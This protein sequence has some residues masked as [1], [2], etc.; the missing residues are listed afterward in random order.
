VRVGLSGA[1]GVGK[2]TLVEALGVRLV[3]SGEHVAVLAVDP[4]STR[5]GGSILGDKTRMADLARHPAAFIRPSPSRG[6]LGGVTRRTREVLLLCEAAGFG[7]V[8]VETVGVGQSEVAVADLV[9]TFVLLIGPGGGDELQGV[10]RG[11]MEL[12]D[13]IAVTK[14]DGDLASAAGRVQA[15]H[16]QAVAF[17]R[18]RHPAWEP[19]VIACSGLTGHGVDELWQAVRDHRHTIRADLGDIRAGQAVRW[20]WD[21]VEAGLVER[22]MAETGSARANE[23]EIAVRER[24]ALPAAEARR[25]L[26]DLGG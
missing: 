19:R 5:S 18:R 2:S 25:L 23:A 17:L 13:V 4:S 20:F 11:I 1:P 12:A 24:R 7:V 22:L 16:R 14:A 3:E 6:D 26:S 10:K 9:D 21:E 15:D 8:L